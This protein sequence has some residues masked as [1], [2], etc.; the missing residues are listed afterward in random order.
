[1]ALSFISS[2]P[3]IL[4]S[5]NNE[6]SLRSA[7]GL[8]ASMHSSLSTIS[9][10]SLFLENRH[11]LPTMAPLLPV[12]TLL[13]LGMQRILAFLVL[14]H[15]W[16]LVLAI[17]SS[18]AFRNFHRVCESA[19]ST[20][21]PQPIFKSY[22]FVLCFLI[23]EL[24]VFFR[25]S[26]VMLVVKNPP[27]SAGDMRDMGLIPRLGR[28]SGEGHGT[29]LQCSYLENPWDRGAWW[30]TVHR[31]AELDTTKMHEFFIYFVY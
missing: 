28:C 16:G 26:Q 11:S 15:F 29:P 21:G 20:E 5:L 22:F 24:Y 18:A 9:S 17:L 7:V 8:S 6:H 27:A 23:I 31:V 13:S 14:C 10:F 12:M 1:M 2:Q 25:A 4:A 19:A 30:A 3:K